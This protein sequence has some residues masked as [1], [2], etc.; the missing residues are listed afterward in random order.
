MTLRILTYNIRGLPWISCPI[1]DILSWLLKRD[2]DIV[3]L[4]EVF[5]RPLQAAI[6]SCDE[7]NVFFSQGSTCAGRAAGFYSGAGLCILV[8]RGIKL[9]GEASFHQFIDASGLDYFV[10]KGILQVSLEFE[11]QRIDIFNTHCQSDFT[12]FSWFRINY[13]SIRNNQEEQLAIVSKQCRY[14]LICGDLNKNSFNYFQKFDLQ[15]E[16]TFPET[17]E[18]LD[19]LLYPVELSSLFHN[20]KTTY[21]HDIELSDHIPV[22]Y[23]F[24]FNKPHTPHDK[25]G[26]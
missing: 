3:C 2:C 7:W 17:G 23:Q 4:Q 19:H 13:P 18:H 1:D 12:E 21:F 26:M 10:S 16:I 22:V 24:E 9:L 5:T 15:D 6:E 20:K 14:P 8:R 25:L 11:G